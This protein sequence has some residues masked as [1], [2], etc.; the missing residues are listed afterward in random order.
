LDFG[1]TWRRTADGTP[2]LR[3]CERQVNRGKEVGLVDRFAKERHG[4][5]THDLFACA[6]IAVPAQEH[7]VF[8]APLISKGILELGAGHPVHSNIQDKAAL[9]KM[10]ISEQELRCGGKALHIEA[11]GS[12]KPGDARAH[13]LF[14]VHD[15]YQCIT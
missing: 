2:D 3:G 12:K 10:L 1:R 14:V 8:I 15:K 11:R 5:F 6:L 13:F 4:S 9:S 7:N